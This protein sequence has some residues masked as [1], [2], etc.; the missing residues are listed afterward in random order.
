MLL[1]GPASAVDFYTRMQICGLRAVAGIARA[2]PRNP[3]CKQIRLALRRFIP[4]RVGEND[5]GSAMKLIETLAGYSDVNVSGV[6]VRFE[7][8]GRRYLGYVDFSPRT[9]QGEVVEVSDEATEQPVRAS[10][11][12]K[13]EIMKAADTFKN[14]SGESRQSPASDVSR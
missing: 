5:Q 13:A 6:V 9:P 8:E 11:T 7:H 1:L 12:V 3:S 4:V 2:V 10:E 14:A